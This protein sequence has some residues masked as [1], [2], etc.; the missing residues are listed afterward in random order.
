M[1]LEAMSFFLGQTSQIKRGT[2]STTGVCEGEELNM[3]DCC[4]AE[5]PQMEVPMRYHGMHISQ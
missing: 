5:K 1:I 2:A 3:E 4:T